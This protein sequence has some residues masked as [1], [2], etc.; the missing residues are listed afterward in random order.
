MI[1]QAVQGLALLTHA[2]AQ[3]GWQVQPVRDAL[4]AVQGTGH[5]GEKR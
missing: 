5:A 3:A 2:C 1:A 4:L